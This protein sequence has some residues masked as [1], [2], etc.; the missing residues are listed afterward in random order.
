V[1]VTGGFVGAT[2]AG[3]T[4]TLGRGGSDLSATLIGVALGVREVQI[5]TDVDG[6]MTADPRVV[7]GARTLESVGFREASELAYFGA[8]VLHP[9]TIHPAVAD[10]I[11]VRVRNTLRPEARGSTIAEPPLVPPPVPGTLLA[12]AWK[13]PIA[14]VSLH[15]GRMLGAHG[16]LARVFEVFARWETPVDVVTTSE[17]SVSL[18]VDRFEHLDAIRHE[19]EQVAEVKVERDLALVCLVGCQLLEHPEL[20]GAILTTLEGVPL[21]M[22]CLGSSDVN[23]TLVVERARA[24]EVVRRLHER[25]LEAAPALTEVGGAALNANG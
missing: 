18:S 2:A 9:D 24:E 6:L 17:V 22:F 21:R 19:L 15:S 20:L 16:F 7:R 25:F 3:L 5:W 4:T 10:R 13:S 1:P 11:P 23:L 8:K 12:V 14:A